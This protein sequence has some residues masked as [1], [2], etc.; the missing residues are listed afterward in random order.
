MS[1][2]A[3][4][5]PKGATLDSGRYVLDTL[6][7][8]APTAGIWSGR[9]LQELETT[10]V[11]ITLRKVVYGNDLDGLLRFAAPGISP[12]VFIGS[13]DGYTPPT[14]KTNLGW[15]VAVVEEKPDGDHLGASGRLSP[16]DVVRLG[17]GLCDLTSAWACR[18][19]V[20]R[21]LRPE[22]VYVCG[23]PGERRFAGAVP[24]SGFLLADDTMYSAFPANHYD[25]PAHDIWTHL[26]AKDLLFT[27][28]MILWFALLGEHPYDVKGDSVT[29]NTWSGRRRP[30]TGPE[31]L[32]VLLDMVLMAD[33]EKR[34]SP[35]ELRERLVR[36]AR[37]WNIEEPPFPSTGLLH[38]L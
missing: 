21:G 23:Q 31:E 14:R 13:P 32:G 36:L 24:R 18:G 16:E 20:I 5:Y 26:T 19:T 28:G 6:I 17:L 9:S 34:L 11:L 29:N 38:S 4:S 27:V 35:D 22:T 12:L 37:S 3:D 25:P 10:S 8:G 2:D 33:A 7:A 30:F 15:D 1:N